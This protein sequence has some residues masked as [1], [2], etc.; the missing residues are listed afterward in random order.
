[1]ERIKYQMVGENTK[2]MQKFI[3]IYILFLGKKKPSNL[4]NF[5]VQRACSYQ[6][7]TKIKGL[8]KVTI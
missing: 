2:K 8:C 5:M 7:R 1:M 4:I 3:N 6:N